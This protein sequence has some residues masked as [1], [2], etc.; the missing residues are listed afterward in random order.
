[1]VVERTRHSTLFFA[2]PTSQPRTIFVVDDDPDTTELY[3]RYLRGREYQ[4]RTARTAQG[5]RDLLDQGIPDLVV[6][7]VLLPGEDGWTVLQ[8][9]KTMPET[10]YVPIVVCSVLSQPLLALA[11]GAA[12]VLR[13]PVEQQALL[14]AVTQALH[15]AENRD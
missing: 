10:A 6:L 8:Q 2:L 1:M 14:R 4:I 5:V 15:S 9:L 11:L 13:K 7:D 3:A 12:E